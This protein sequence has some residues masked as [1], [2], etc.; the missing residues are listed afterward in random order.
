MLWRLKQRTNALKKT[1]LRK[2]CYPCANTPGRR[3]CVLLMDVFPTSPEGNALRLRLS[4]RLACS[5]WREEAYSGTTAVLIIWFDARAIASFLISAVSQFLSTFLLF[6]P[7]YLSLSFP[8]CTPQNSF[9]ISKWLPWD[10]AE[11]LLT[12]MSLGLIVHLD[13]RQTRIAERRN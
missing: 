2:N 1:A 8:L 12:E 6:C 11:V 10:S 4:L 3:C 13:W 9:M 5:G 7:D